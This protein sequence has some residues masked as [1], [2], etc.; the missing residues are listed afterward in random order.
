M[1]EEAT[2]YPIDSRCKDCSLFQVVEE[3]KKEIITLKAKVASLEKE[4]E[5]YRKPP[6]DSN[7]SSIPSSQNRWNKKYPKRP[8]STNKVG[9]QFGHIGCN[10]PYLEPTEVIN[11]NDNICPYCGSIHLEEKISKLKRK[12]IVDLEI[13]PLVKEYQQHHLICCNCKRKIPNQ[14]FPIT[15]NVKY[16]DNIRKIIGYLNIQHNCSYVRLP[17]IFEDLFNIKISKGSIDNILK[18]LSNALKDKYISIQDFIKNSTIIGSDETGMRINNKNCYLWTFQNEE[19]T[20]FVGSKTRSYE[21]VRDVIGEDFKGTWVSDRYGGQ[22]KIDCSHQ[23][24]SSHLIRDCN[25]AIDSDNTLFPKQLKKILK[26]TI[27]FKNRYGNEYNPNTKEIFREKERYKERLSNIF[28]KKPNQRKEETRK[29]W[30]S[31]VYRQKDLLLFLEDKNIPAT[32]NASER[33]LRNRVIKNKVSGCF[34]SELGAFCNDILSS[35]IETAK[36][37]KVSLLEALDP[38]HSFAF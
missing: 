5:Q 19:A 26:E 27:K 20:L 34:R 38:S 12:Q 9:G 30:N 25:Y 22:L 1:K 36:K 32:N 13:T 2:Q 11:L 17:Q 15:G 8:K 7:N 16:G 23:L 3:L 37:Q 21:V 18:G 33:A 28:Q 6:K 29:L 35:V 14:P 4:L 10:K 24:C 31:L